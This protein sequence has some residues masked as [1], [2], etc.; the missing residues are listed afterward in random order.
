MD[1]QHGIIGG[2]RLECDI[3]MPSNASESARVVELVSKTTAFL[4]LFATDYADLVAKL[5]AFFSK[6]V[7]MET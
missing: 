4:L 3:G 5:A 7:D 2:H 6:G 1:F